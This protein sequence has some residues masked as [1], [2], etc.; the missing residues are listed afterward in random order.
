[1]HNYYEKTKKRGFGKKMCFSS[2]YHFRES[3]LLL[4]V[5]FTLILILGSN[6]LVL[7]GRNEMSI[8]PKIYTLEGIIADHEI[9][10]ILSNGRKLVY[11]KDGNVLY[12]LDGSGSKLDATI[13]VTSEEDRKRYES[14]DFSG[15]YIDGNGDIIEADVDGNLIRLEQDDSPSYFRNEEFLF[16][17][18]KSVDPTEDSEALID[19]MLNG[20]TISYVVNEKRIKLDINYKKTELFLRALMSSPEAR[21]MLSRA[22]YSWDHG[23]DLSK[24]KW[25]L[26]Y[27]KNSA[28]YAWQGTGTEILINKGIAG[29]L[30][31]SIDAREAIQ[32][33]LKKMNQPNSADSLVVSG[34]ALGS[35]L[36][37]RILA[38]E[39][40]ILHFRPKDDNHYK[41]YAFDDAMVSI[42][43]TKG[44]YG[45]PITVS[46]ADNYYVPWMGVEPG[47]TV[48]INL[49]YTSKDFQ[50]DSLLVLEGNN[51]DIRFLGTNNHYIEL[52]VHTKSVRFRIETTGSDFMINAYLMHKGSS[53]KLLIGCLNIETK[54]MPFEKKKLRII[55]V[56]RNDE[57]VHFPVSREDKEDLIRNINE[58]Y[59]QA[60]IRFEEDRPGYQDTLTINLSTQNRIIDIKK[61]LYDILPFEQQNPE[62]Y[63]I[64]ICSKIK[65]GQK[66]IGGTP[67]NYSA[68][69]L[70]L[71]PKVPLLPGSLF[72][73]Y[74]ATAAHELGHN[75]GLLHTFR[76]RYSGIRW[77]GRI[78][79]M[80]GRHLNKLNTENIMDYT[81]LGSDPR[82]HF[83][84]FQIDFLNRNN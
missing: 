5:F 56:K 27:T 78:V 67:G 80:E 12:V 82:Y 69:F 28:S 84:K 73:D 2:S 48:E 21:K 79:N 36:T 15:I 13:P 32:V 40:G 9:K 52:D 76:D 77:E 8:Y 57:A 23:I 16:V 26:S 59:N 25:R 75:L 70:P 29:S 38:V 41:Y 42:F 58:Y 24:I 44:D 74:Y 14:G 3:F 33:V 37:G 47:R 61:Y 68:L 55:R 18:V 60:F 53:E 62:V 35:L 54:I 83:F 7:Y 6:F 34:E 43:Q 71:N 22:Y 10:N 20:H 72:E 1:M 39:K 46:G 63:Y 31:L 49:D 50:S 64:F 11:D 45:S 81:Y 30:D 17:E 65:E 19:T 66:G 51:Q 4:K